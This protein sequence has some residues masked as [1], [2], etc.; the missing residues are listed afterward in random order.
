LRGR[1]AYV[2][3]RSG[4]AATSHDLTSALKEGAGAG[5]QWSR[6]RLRGTLV[7]IQVALCLV[8]L[9]SAGLL[10]RSLANAYTADAGF[11]AHRTAVVQLDS[12]DDDTD[13]T[14]HTRIMERIQALPGVESIAA[15]AG[16]PLLSSGR[17]NARAAKDVTLPIAFNHVTSGYFQTLGIV[18]LSGRTF[19]ASEERGDVPA[20]VL[21]ESA[22]RKLYGSA[23]A[24]GQTLRVE[25]RSDLHPLSTVVGVARDTRSV[26]LAEIDPAYAYFP[27]TP[28]R[29][30]RSAHLFVRTPSGAEHM[31]APIRRVTSELTTGWQPLFYTLEIATGYQR[32]PA[33]AGAIVAA[34]LGTLALVLACVGIY[35][36]ISYTVSQR[37]HEIGVRMALGASAHDVIRLVLRQGMKLVGVGTAVG[38]CAAAP[39]ANVLRFVLYG[40]NPL[41]AWT[42]LAVPALLCAIALTAMSAPV[43]RAARVQPTATL[44]QD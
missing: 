25:T 16:V 18:I 36:V 14:L 21:S 44:R 1:G 40:V 8:L 30:A 4:A 3:A 43:L 20:V 34:V 41:D 10:A 19:T 26:R 42:F 33:E 13:A 29:L 11:D 9:I 39:V 35:G 7:V 5:A 24:I 6:S 38:I 22:A 37:T 2:R 12:R 32:L 31:L 28:K 23:E 15:A 27:L 17:T